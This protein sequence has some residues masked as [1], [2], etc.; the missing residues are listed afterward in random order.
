MRLS[1]CQ[2]RT[3]D[4]GH[5]VTRVTIAIIDSLEMVGIVAARNSDGKVRR[6]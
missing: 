5:V 1:R 3:N 2:I 4:G 6:C